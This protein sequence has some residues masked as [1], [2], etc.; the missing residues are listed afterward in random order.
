MYIKRAAA[1]VVI[2][3][4]VFDILVD[5]V[6]WICC[7]QSNNMIFTMLNSWIV[8]LNKQFAI[9]HSYEFSSVFSFDNHFWYNN[10]NKRKQNEPHTENENINRFKPHVRMKTIECLT[11]LLNTWN[12]GMEWGKRRKFICDNVYFIMLDDLYI[13]ELYMQNAL[14]QIYSWIFVIFSHFYIFFGMDSNF[15]ICSWFSFHLLFSF[16]LYLY[17]LSFFSSFKWPSTAIC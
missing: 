2:V 1:T 8:V 10:H 11:K 17:T 14:M 13:V 16:L 15:L 4:I 5:S 7:G 9:F 6:S 3:I 12:V